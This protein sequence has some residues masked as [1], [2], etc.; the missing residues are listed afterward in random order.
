MN[1]RRWLA[2]S[3]VLI[4]VA[5]GGVA[6]GLLGHGSR[7]RVPAAPPA[8]RPVGPA[9]VPRTTVPPERPHRSRVPRAP[10]PTYGAN[11]RRTGT[12]PRS[13]VRPPFRRRWAVDA[14]SLIEFP[15]VIADGRLFLGTNGGR[16]L[17]VEAAT[18]RIAWE[19][20]FGRCIAASPAVSHGVVYVSLMDPSP[21][22][23]HNHRAPG[24]AVALREAD[25]STLWR[26]TAGPI[27]S[28]PLVA[29]GRVYVG[30]WDNRVYALDA[31]TGRVVWRFRTGGAVKGGAALDRGTL[32]I[33]SYDGHL[34]ALDARSGRV[35]WSATVGASMYATPVV[36]D[37]EV[38]IGALNGALHAFALDNGRPRWT[39]Q[40]GS[41][42]YSSAA[43]F[44]GI[45]FVG[46]YDRRLYA[47]DA[48]TGRIRWTFAAAGPVSGTPTVIAGIVY[49]A[50]C[51]ICIA[52]VARAGVAR[53]Y[54]VDA[55]TGRLLWWQ[56]GGQYTPVVADEQRAYVIGYRHLFGMGPAVAR[57]GRSRRP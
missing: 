18:G 23:P 52:G 11:A 14:G 30:S 22:A 17:A 29:G 16:F 21:C 44:D 36:T 5:G 33:G 46:S 15:P 48:E 43:A 2:G 56:R 12:A 49:F 7:P 41:Y 51:P 4:A 54:G 53:T 37:G 19:R 38:V 27:E 28:S 9:P 26:F 8:T 50:T 10:W 35:R 47:L 39:V 13:R 40:T 20:R 31:R 6:V 57:S 3:F 34:Y 45:V 32:F 24:Y 55:R 42:I 1:L 25:G